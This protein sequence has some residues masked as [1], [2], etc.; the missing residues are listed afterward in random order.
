MS[1]RSARRWKP[2]SGE[3]CAAVVCAA[4]AL[5][6]CRTAGPVV[7][8]GGG[9]GSSGLESRREVSPEISKDALL[10]LLAE[11]QR[12]ASTI[13]ALVDVRGPTGSFLGM[14]QM[15]L[16][17]HIRFQG[18]DPLGRTAFDFISRGEDFA[19]YLPARREVITGR[20]D[21]LAREAGPAVPVPLP[22]L[23]AAVSALVSPFVD[24][25]E[26]AA[27]ERRDGAYLLNI[28][29][30]D[31]GRPSASGGRLVRR[32]WFDEVRLVLIREEVFGPSGT[33][34]ATFTLEDFR[35]LGGE[36][37]P[38]RLILARASPPPQADEAGAPALT[39]AVR[40]LLV[41]PRL[42]P[43]AFAFGSLE[44][45]TVREVGQEP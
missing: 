7:A 15:R 11:R 29:L 31:P 4:V 27:L 42:D 1:S 22:D 26:A 8:G 25:E 41:N 33:P 35:L 24:V 32:L 21:A 9:P 19:L 13:K 14:L 5:L 28:F 40:E 23:L 39:I 3:V 43:E 12:A 38:H 30:S 10:T 44:G 6:G 16:P 18:L 34:R 2:C 17:E 45:V 20:V 37:R 36:W